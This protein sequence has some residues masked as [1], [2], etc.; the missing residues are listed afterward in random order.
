MSKIQ[1]IGLHFSP[2][3]AYRRLF[4]HK[5]DTV[6]SEKDLMNTRRNT[7]SNLKHMV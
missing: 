3:D 2:S 5:L 7:V 6:L 4:C 1:H